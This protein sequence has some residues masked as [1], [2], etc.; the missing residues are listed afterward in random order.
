M[1]F[2]GNKNGKKDETC[3]EN[4][5]NQFNYFKLALDK[6]DDVDILKVLTM[7]GI[8]T[9]RTHLW[10]QVTIAIENH[11]HAEPELRCNTNKQQIIQ[12]HEVVLCMDNKAKQFIDCP[13]STD[14]PVA[15]CKLAPFNF[16]P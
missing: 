16:P 5:F 4:N 3:S 7:G 13:Q 2:F 9:G 11:I 15:L 10:N 8:I 6:K 12:L 1:M 14:R